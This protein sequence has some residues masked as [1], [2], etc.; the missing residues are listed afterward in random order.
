MRE[1][2]AALTSHELDEL[3][4]LLERRSGIRFD[5]AREDIFAA[6]VREFARQAEADGVELLR[7]LTASDDEYEALLERLLVQDTSFFRNAGWFGE[8][9]KRIIPEM[10]E[11]KFWDNP[12]TLRIWSAACSTGEEPYSIAIAVS[13]ALP[14]AEAW[15]IEILATDISRRALQHAERGVYTARA[16]A[17]LS[18]Q[19]IENYFTK[20]PH[21][22]VVKPRIRKMVSFAPVNLT[23]APYVG[24]MDC[25]FG[26]NALARFSEDRRDS[27]AHRFIESLEPG[28][29]LVLGP[30]ECLTAPPARLEC[31]TLG[32]CRLYRRPAREPA[33]R[34]AVVAEGSL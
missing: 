7:R 15:R 4:A 31:V 17:N 18:P 34:Q 29:Y 20:T 26:T 9:G 13:D 19:Q 3:R 28:G 5:D 6:R 8:L 10:Q 11:R 33:L 27:V 22:F 14:F 23:D 30:A 12:R 24:R 16:V 21:G 1:K 32:D 2:P 25:I